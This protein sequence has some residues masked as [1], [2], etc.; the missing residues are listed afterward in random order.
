MARS[1]EL[2]DEGGAPVGSK[3]VR[4]DLGDKRRQ[5]GQN[6]DLHELAGQRMEQ[7]SYL[8]VT[9]LE[10]FLEPRASLMAQVDEQGRMAQAVHVTLDEEAGCPP[11]ELDLT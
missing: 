10:E 3:T 8:D 7:A 2:N 6:T 4:F 11:T 9:E 1:S 5:S